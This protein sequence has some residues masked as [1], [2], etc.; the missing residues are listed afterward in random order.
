MVNMRAMAEAFKTADTKAASAR[1]KANGYR[2]GNALRG[3]QTALQNAL[4]AAGV[5]QE[6]ARKHAGSWFSKNRR[7]A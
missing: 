1:V 2:D 5:S 3:A 6:G 7:P 4:V